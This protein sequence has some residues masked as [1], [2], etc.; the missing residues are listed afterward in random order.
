MNEVDPIIK[1]LVVQPNASLSWRGAH[2]FVWI[3]CAGV[4]GVAGVIG[5]GVLLSGHGFSPMGAWPVFVFAGLNIL[6]LSTALAI[7]LHRNDYRQVLS[8]E[9]DEIRIECGFAGRGTK[10]RYTLSRRATRAMLEP[11]PYRNSPT[12]LM[13]RG[14]GRTVEIGRELTDEQR[15]S[16]CC[17]IR[18][19]LQPGWTRPA[20]VSPGMINTRV[21]HY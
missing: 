13:L 14:D 10:T 16:L 4:L 15:V 2:R 3:V 8:F 7:S 21:R 12:V 5:T 17:R 11:G 19:L 20:P 1:R 18:E 6:A 9:E